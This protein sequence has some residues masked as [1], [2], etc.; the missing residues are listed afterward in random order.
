LIANTPATLLSH[1]LSFT[2]TTTTIMRNTPVQLAVFLFS[3]VCAFHVGG[4]FGGK[5]EKGKRTVSDL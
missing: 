3:L 2:T 1:L 4:A 5:K